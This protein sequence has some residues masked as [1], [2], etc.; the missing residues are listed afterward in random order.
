[1]TVKTRRFSLLEVLVAMT[2][3]AIAV[4]PVLTG[5]HL[6]MRNLETGRRF[7]TAVLIAQSRLCREVATIMNGRES[8]APPPLPAGYTC[9]VTQSQNQGFIAV[10]VTVGFELFGAP[11]EFC[12]KSAVFAGN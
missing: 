10:Q 3:L 4:V 9:A 1:M 12:L 6:A 8:G 5:F 11:R 7:H 2:I